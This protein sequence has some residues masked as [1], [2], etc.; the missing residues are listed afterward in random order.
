MRMVICPQIPSALNMWKN[1]FNQELNVH[2][3][4]HVRQMDI[5]TAEPL[6]PEHSLVKVEIATGKLERYKSPGTDQIPAKLIKAGGETY[7]LRY[8][9]LF[10]LYGIRRNFHSNGRSLLLY[11]YVKKAIR[12][13]VITTEKSPSY[14]LPTKF[15][16]PSF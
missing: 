7:V 2:G 12:P 6:M 8:T 9:N 13:T 10:A 3:V 1:F 4:H 11:Q 5:H 14:Q 15:Y 16:P